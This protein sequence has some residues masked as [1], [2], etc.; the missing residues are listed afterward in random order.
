MP[1]RLE[2]SDVDVGG[3]NG[4]LIVDSLEVLQVRCFVLPL[5]TKYEV[6]S[7]RGGRTDVSDILTSFT[8]QSLIIITKRRRR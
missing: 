1:T 3:V 2:V 6:L 5:S 8:S 7:I 4:V